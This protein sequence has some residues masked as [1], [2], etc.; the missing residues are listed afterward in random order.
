MSK[1]Q[2]FLQV[3]S[4]VQ[5]TLKNRQ[6]L[7]KKSRILIAVSGGQDSLC[8]AQLLLKLQKK[9]QWELAIAHCDHQWEHDQGIADHVRNFAEY[10]QLPFYLK[11]PRENIKE[12]E[13]EARKW[14]YQGLIEMATEQNFKY[15]VTAHTKSDRAETFLY[16]LMRG[17]GADGLQSMNW[18][19]P[20]TSEIELVRPILDISRAETLQFCQELNLKI[21]EDVYND[22]LKY[23]RN[24]IRKELIPYLEDN[25]NNQ[26]QSHLA[27]TAELLKADVEYLEEQAEIWFKKAV[28]KAE[29]GVIKY[30]LD[31]SILK[32][33][34]LALQRRVIRRFLQENLSHAPN[35]QDIE[36]VTNLIKAENQSKTDPLV[37]GIIAI[38][39]GNLIIFVIN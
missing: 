31:R 4:Q 33:V 26:I 19:R 12:T 27:Q 6:L 11:T 25:F 20:L 2:V 14:R 1:N 38:A 39:Q 22:H 35:F 23:A 18:K 15:I 8:L 36:K 5:R 21:W 28:I 37:G 17:S 3:I 24:R 10:L 7:P 34:P 32:N 29:E 30:S 9:W 13:G 16:N